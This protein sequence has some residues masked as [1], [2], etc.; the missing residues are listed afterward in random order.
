MLYN[1][2]LNSNEWENAMVKSELIVRIF[3]RQKNFPLQDVERGVNAILRCIGDA[4]A[5][6]RRSE[7]R[8]FGS[9]S[10]HY[11]PPRQ[12]HNPRTRIKLY[13]KGKYKPHF[14]PGKE[15]KNRVNDNRHVPIKTDTAD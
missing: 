12:A 10:C 9:F 7:I 1:V 13:T 8:G 4:L 15:L 11:H 2:A 14:K 3:K 5:K 6:G